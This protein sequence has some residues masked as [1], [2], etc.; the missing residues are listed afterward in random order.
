MGRLFA[1]FLVVTSLGFC[2][3]AQ[4]VSFRGCVQWLMSRVRGGQ[5]AVHSSTILIAGSPR[6]DPLIS[7]EFL[8]SVRPSKLSWAQLHG[9]VALLYQLINWQPDFVARLGLSIDRDGDLVFPSVRGLNHRIRLLRAERHPLAPSVLFWD[10][11]SVSGSSLWEY[12]RHLGEGEAPVNQGGVDKF[13]ESLQ[14]HDVLVHMAGFLLFPREVIDRMKLRNRVLSELRLHPHLQS[15]DLQTAL[16][17]EAVREAYVRVESGTVFAALF[18]QSQRQEATTVLSNVFRTLGE[19]VRVL[20]PALV[21]ATETRQEYLA[22]RRA[23]DPY[24]KQR[25]VDWTAVAER[26]LSLL[27]M[28]RP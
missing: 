1:V 3:S 14:Y 5:K 9:D 7:G 10:D 25:D 8:S 15:T 2:E 21:A 28:T 23:L 11:F 20:E 13:G 16:E 26:R 6:P 4:A 27:H 17:N 12:I 24:R 22:L 19:P 18:S